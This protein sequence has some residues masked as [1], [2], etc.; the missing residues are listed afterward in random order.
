MMQ[1]QNFVSGLGRQFM[2]L[3]Q[4]L[5]R[6]FQRKKNTVIAGPLKSDLVLRINQRPVTV[7]V[8]YLS[9]RV[10]LYINQQFDSLESEDS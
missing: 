7:S 1:E 10:V 4:I 3:A 5:I 9:S 2:M 6:D 8:S